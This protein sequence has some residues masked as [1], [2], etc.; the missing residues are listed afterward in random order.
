MSE[1]KR[2]RDPVHGL[3]KFDLGDEVDRAAWELINTSEFQRLRRVKQLGVS[4]FIYPGATHTRLAHSI[5][6]FHIARDLMKV[7][8]RYVPSDK[9]KPH[10]AKTALLAALLH[11]VGHGPFSHA[12]EN[13]EKARLTNEQYHDHEYWTAELICR[14]DGNIRRILKNTFGGDGSVADDIAAMLRG[15]EQD[16]Y[17]SVVSSSFDADRLDYLRRDRMMTGS[18]AG[19]IDF[20]WLLDNLRV[21]DVPVSSGEDA[22]ENQDN[23]IQVF[24][25]EEKA[26]QAV[27]TFIL[28][29]FQLYAQVYLHKTTRGIEQMLTAFLLAF[30]TEAAKGDK[31]NLA[32]P[33]DH[34]LRKFYSKAKPDLD[35]Y[36]ALDDAVVWSAMEISAKNGR[37]RVKEF[38]DR[39]CSRGI[40]RGVAID[41]VNPQAV[42]KARREFIVKQFGGEL[43]K[44]VF[45]DRAPLSIYKDPSK[46]TVKPHKRVY[47]R[48]KSQ[49]VVDV[50]SLSKPVAALFEEQEILRYYFLNENDRKKVMSVTGE[51][52]AAV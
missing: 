45:E 30:S 24:A 29:R 33:E 39:I 1:L 43:G 16:L 27:E 37:G 18:G 21:V 46:E 20:E 34:P 4:E 6:V 36:F 48:R 5:G 44:T 14:K 19:A 35:D 49:K 17:S 7:A 31:A 2:I 38:A 52:H 41:T 22:E 42:D 3:I 26:L 25:F 8:E 28:A 40:M 32:V 51:D 11:D 23:T 47:I 13:A 15:K 12:F 9:Q 10:R 50:T